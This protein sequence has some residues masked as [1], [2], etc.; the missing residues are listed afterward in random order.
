[1]IIFLI[2]LLLTNRLVIQLYE[3]YMCFTKYNVLR[4]YLAIYTY[5]PFCKKNGCS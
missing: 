5:E 2:I 3:L 4:S 1:V